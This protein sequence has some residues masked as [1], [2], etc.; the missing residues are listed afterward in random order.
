MY[1][2]KKIT[3]CLPC[4]N[5][6]KHLHEV[7]KMIPNFVDEIIIVSNNSSDDT[8]FAA[9]NLGVK[10]FE[11]DRTLNGNGEGFAYQ[12][13]IRNATG[14]IIICADADCTY[15]TDKIDEMLDVFL[16]KELDFMSGS[17]YPKQKGAEIGLKNQIGVTV[18]NWEIF[19]LYGIDIKDSLSGMWVFKKDIIPELGILTNNLIGDWNHSP[20][21]KLNA[22]GNPNLKCA[23][24]PITQYARAGQTH[25]AYLKTGFGHLV[26]ILLNRFGITRSKKMDAV[27]DPI[28]LHHTA[29]TLPIYSNEANFTLRQQYAARLRIEEE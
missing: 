6:S 3:V 22:F 28:D 18:L 7:I 15:P 13:A 11:D 26:W 25:Q 2:N 10:V 17:R 8:Y 14:D 24:Y 5:E 27:L 12:T 21:I 9:K 4:K 16:A 19:F 20:Q 23:E 29:K 1:K